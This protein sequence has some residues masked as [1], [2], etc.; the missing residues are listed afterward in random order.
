MLPFLNLDYKTSIQVTD[1][2]LPHLGRFAENYRVENS[3]KSDTHLPLWE[4][5]LRC[6]VRKAGGM[7]QWS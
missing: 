1:I 3:E 2:F 6:P 4:P 7:G 5:K